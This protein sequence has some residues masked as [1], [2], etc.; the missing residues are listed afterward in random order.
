MVELM[1]NRDVSWRDG[2]MS[3]SPA[4][5]GTEPHKLAEDKYRMENG[6]YPFDKVPTAV[7]IMSEHLFG[8]IG[9]QTIG[10]CCGLIVVKKEVKQNGNSN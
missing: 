3:I 9:H 6:I 2:F 1:K 7:A 4:N 10:E 8:I 5:C